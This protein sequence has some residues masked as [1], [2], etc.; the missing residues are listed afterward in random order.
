M[1]IVKELADYR[2]MNLNKAKISKKFIKEMAARNINDYFQ[3]L[4]QALASK[5]QELKRQSFQK[6]EKLAKKSNLAQE[7]VK[8][9]SDKM[10]AAAAKNY[11][12][13]FKKTQAFAKNKGLKQADVNEAV[14]R[15][16]QGNKY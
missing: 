10:K 8:D 15:A 14:K 2:A 12:C 4:E 1:M 7:D 11:D 9:F 13:L 6:A 5:K 16:G 3:D